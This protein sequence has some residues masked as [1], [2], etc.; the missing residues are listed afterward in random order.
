MESIANMLNTPN[1]GWRTARGDV[2]ATD[3]ALTNT[4]MDSLPTGAVDILTAIDTKGRMPINAVQ[5][6]LIA[7]GSSGSVDYTVFAGRH[8]QGPAIQI[9]DGTFTLGTMDVLQTPVVDSGITDLTGMHYAQ[10]VTATDVH[11]KSVTLS[12]DQG[13]NRMT[14]LLFDMWGYDWLFVQIDALTTVTK[15]SVIW[16]A[17]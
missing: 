8:G 11:V 13:N 16:S 17:I 9:C 14:S 4:T 10:S 12:K 7:D 1:Y 6:A 2:T 5:L 3:T 15:A